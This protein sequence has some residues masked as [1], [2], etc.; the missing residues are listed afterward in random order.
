[1]GE[2][3]RFELHLEGP[4]KTLEFCRGRR[5]SAELGVPSQ[6]ILAGVV[7]WITIVEGLSR[8]VG[9]NQTEDL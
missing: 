1:M 7:N 8:E 2:A 6:I 5:S 4:I 9:W 3:V